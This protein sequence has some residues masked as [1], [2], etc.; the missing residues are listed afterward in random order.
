MAALTIST[1]GG[2]V[3]VEHDGKGVILTVVGSRTILT[4]ADANLLADYLTEPASS[5]K[6][7][8]ADG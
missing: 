8:K 1:P 3:E 2:I 6:T 7:S 5:K 4:T